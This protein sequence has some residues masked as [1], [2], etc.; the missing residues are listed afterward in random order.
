MSGRTRAAAGSLG[1]LLACA[2]IAIGCGDD[3]EDTS[4]AGA[5]DT[6][7]ESSG[8]PAEERIDEAVASCTSAAEDLG[9]ASGAALQAA[10]ATIADNVKLALASG[11]EQV[12]EA[13][14]EAADACDEAVTQLPEGDAQAALSDL[15]AAIE[16]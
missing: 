5:P 10:C 7:T 2:V 8:T 15:C 12:E 3:D 9:D 4:S 6:T 14:S 11:G 13:L 1:L 16:A